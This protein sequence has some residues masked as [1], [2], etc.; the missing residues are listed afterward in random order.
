MELFFKKPKSSTAST[1]SIE[2]STEDHIGGDLER[3]ERE[4]NMNTAMEILAG[5]DPNHYANRIPEKL[6]EEYAERTGKAY[7]SGID[8]Q[9]NALEHLI[10]EF[11][12]NGFEEELK[13]LKQK[14]FH[15][16]ATYESAL[17]GGYD[18]DTVLLQKMY[19]ESKENYEKDFH[20]SYIP[21]ITTKEQAVAFAK[22][23]SDKKNIEHTPE[24]VIAEIE[25]LQST[26]EKISP[27]KL[28]QEA[29]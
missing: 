18:G 10:T 22:S 21:Q 27:E 20:E 24:E 25:K 26:K 17:L 2:K 15:V 29:T 16:L 28:F 8:S 1:R 9:P 19:N 3:M 7:K 5:K 14:K 12:G 13:T 4:L 11:P 23:H 6:K